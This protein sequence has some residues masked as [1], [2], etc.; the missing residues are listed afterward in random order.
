MRFFV[1][2][3]RLFGVRTGVL[4]SQR[5]L[6]FGRGQKSAGSGNMTGGFIYVVKGDHG[7]VKVGVSINPIE[8]LA[9]LQTGSP[10]LLRLDYVGALAD[11]GYGLEAD[12]HA[13]LASYRL[14]GE[15]FN[16]PIEVAVGTLNAVAYKRGDKIAAIDSALVPEII[17]LASVPAPKKGFWGQF[18]KYA[19][20]AFA[21]LVAVDT[22][23]LMFNPHY[24]D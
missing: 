18:W 8:R 23:I 2:G 10:F 15:W 5:D 24:F 13:A 19:G 20:L 1:G 17:R 3:P 16:C 11:F 14:A 21:A 22:V 9:T 6:G 4:L 7:H 12:V